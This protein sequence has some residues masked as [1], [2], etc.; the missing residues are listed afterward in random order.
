MTAPVLVIAIGNASRGDDAVAVLLLKRLAQWLEARG[1]PQCEL[2]EEYQLQVE[3]AMDMLDREL[4]LFIDAG[5]GMKQPCSFAR[6]EAA[7]DHT[8]FSHALSP[9]ALLSAY[10]RVYKSMPPP[11]FVLCVGGEEFELGTPPGRNAERNMEQAFGLLEN[12]FAA[13]NV[14]AWEALCAQVKIDKGVC[15]ENRD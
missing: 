3:H 15:H 13:T 12:L 1:S 4:V 5:V 7:G 14:P 2:L 8:L 11:S 6:V 9:R 10:V